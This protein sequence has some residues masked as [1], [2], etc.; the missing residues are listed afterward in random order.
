M[1]SPPPYGDGRGFNAAFARLLLRLLDSRVLLRWCREK[2]TVLKVERD[3]LQQLVMVMKAS[4][5]EPATP[6]SVRFLSYLLGFTKPERKS[7][8]TEKLQPAKCG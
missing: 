6:P 3:K 8:W 7:G 5:V 4:R 1:G 2:W